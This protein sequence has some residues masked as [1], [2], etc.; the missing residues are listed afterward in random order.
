MGGTC[1]TRGSDG[2]MHKFF[3]LENPKGRDQLEDKPSVT[4]KEE[5]GLFIS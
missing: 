3:F 4:V 1:S 2:E 5:I